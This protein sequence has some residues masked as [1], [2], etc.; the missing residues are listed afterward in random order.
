MPLHSRTCLIPSPLA[1]I[2]STRGPIFET[3]PFRALVK[4][5]Q[6]SKNRCP[7]CLG[8]FGLTW[9]VPSMR[10]LRAVHMYASHGIT[11]HTPHPTTS[12]NFDA[13]SGYL[14]WGHAQIHMYAHACLSA[15]LPACLLSYFPP[16][17]C[18]HMQTCTYLHACNSVSLSLSI[19]LAQAHAYP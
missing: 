19:Y 9:C 10:L 2:C 6:G 18:M 3:L 15:C 4:A 1:S 8:A 7:V 11:S 14:S 5:T 13:C 12:Y 17:A 16:C